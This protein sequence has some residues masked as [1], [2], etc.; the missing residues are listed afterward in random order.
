MGDEMID[1]LLTDQQAH[2]IVE[3]IKIQCMHFQSCM[4]K[5]DS[6]FY[7]PYTQMRQ[8]YS[9]TSAVISGFAPGRFQIEGITSRNLYYGLH[10]GLVQPE[11]SCE[12]GIFHIY[13]GGSSLD[14]KPIKERCEKMNCSIDSPRFFFMIVV[15]VSTKGQLSKVEIC[16]PNQKGEIVN[17]KSIYVKEKIVSITA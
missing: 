6:I 11:L 10:N 3:I 14:G 8:K 16:L 7:G 12:N 2:E 4:K 5:C 13:S 1:Q 9:A 17:R 15:H